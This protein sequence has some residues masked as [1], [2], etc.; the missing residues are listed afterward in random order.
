MGEGIR[1][2]G[3]KGMRSQ[4]AYLWNGEADGFRVINTPPT[5]RRGRM[6][7]SWV[8]GGG[9]YVMTPFHIRLHSLSS[10]VGAILTDVT[11]WLE[12]GSSMSL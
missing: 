4:L 7:E 12:G 9:C 11:R 3:V 1:P 10:A 5:K 6:E 8:R 2:A